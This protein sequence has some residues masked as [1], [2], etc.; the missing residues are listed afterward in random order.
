MLLG[1]V[2]IDKDSF[3]GKTLEGKYIKVK[4]FKLGEDVKVGMCMELDMDGLDYLQI[5][6]IN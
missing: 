4:N 5:E 6:S 3:V 2:K 1:I